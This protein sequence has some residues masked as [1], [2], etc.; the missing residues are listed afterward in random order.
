MKR[1][2]KLLISLVVRAGDVVRAAVSR[3]LG[4][5]APGT[6]VVIYYHGVRPELRE[7]FARQMDMVAQ[8]TMVLPG[9]HAG[10]LAAGQRHSLITFDDG[11][12][13]YLE[14]ALPELESRGLA[15]TIFVPTGSLGVAPRWIQRPG[16]PGLAE[17][18]MTEAQLAA[19]A[20]HGSV[21]IGSHSINHPDF[22]SLD[23][24]AAAT[25]LGASRRHLES[26]IGRAVTTFS[27]PH[28]RFNDTLLD[29]AQQ[30]GYTR[31]FG[32]QPRPAVGDTRSILL[33]RV[34]VE[35]DDWPVEF[36][37]KLLGAYRW[38]ASGD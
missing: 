27:F 14:Q 34:A 1:V 12:V 31:V 30:A 33:G 37:L 23:A 5:P 35:P 29:Q 22:L 13:S 4:R 36:R 19:L 15:S 32:I 20:G 7:A 38:M 8:L 2:V 28:G 6:C 3:S 26:I 10:P 17:V 11:F 9:D 25:E 24:A 16:H 18:V 21:T